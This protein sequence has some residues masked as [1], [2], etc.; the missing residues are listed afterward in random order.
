M[1][2]YDLASIYVVLLIKIF[3]LAEFY[4]HDTEN[5]NSRFETCPRTLAPPGCLR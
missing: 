2:Q 3:S 5:L 1:S 4:D